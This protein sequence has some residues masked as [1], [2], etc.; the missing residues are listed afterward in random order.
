[1]KDCADRQ[2]VLYDVYNV[3]H[4]MLCSSTELTTSR[5]TYIVTLLEC[6]HVPRYFRRRPIRHLRVQRS[7]LWCR[8]HG[9]RTFSTVDAVTER[10]EYTQMTM[11]LN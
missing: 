5:R 11:S 3:D 6:A 7:L 8:L 1:M 9:P 2:D 4:D 10:L